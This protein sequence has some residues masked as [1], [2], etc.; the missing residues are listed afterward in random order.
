MSSVAKK[1]KGGK[2]DGPPSD[3]EQPPTKLEK[4]IIHWVRRNVPTKKTKFNHTHVVEYVAGCKVV[5]A[6]CNQSP[7]AKDKAKPGSEMVFEHREDA[8][9]FMETMLKHKMFHRAAKIAVQDRKKAK[10]SA[11]AAAAATTTSNKSE[12]EEKAPLVKKKRR[13]RLEMHPLQIFLDSQD[14]YVWLYN[15]TPWYYWLGGTIIVLGTIAICLFPLWPPMMRQ[16]VH[17]LSLAAAGFLGFIIGLGIFKYILYALFFLLTC[18][19]LSFWLFPNLTEDVG[20]FESF[21]PAYE[22]TYVGGKKDKDSD[23][24]ESDDEEEEDDEGNAAKGG[25][26]GGEKKENNSESDESTSKKSSTTGKDF[27]MVDNNDDTDVQDE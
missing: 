14:A 16:G 1:T 15:P 23:D 22:Y 5:D 19:K 8:V 24:E 18:G 9:F 12:S 20:F 21:V 10:K 7:W 3:V 13:I 11:A 25:G 17:Y 6:L 26:G 4:S 2:K 27:E